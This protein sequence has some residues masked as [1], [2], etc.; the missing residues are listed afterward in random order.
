MA[1]N[2]FPFRSV[3][4][5]WSNA[6]EYFAII[7][8]KDTPLYIKGIV[9]LAVL[10]LISP[11]DLVPD[12]LAG[13]GIVDDIAVVSLLLSYAIRLVNKRKNKRTDQNNIGK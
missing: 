2:W 1:N 11:F 3:M 6:K 5:L 9:G 8:H 4:H 13:L 12:W 7:T 10:Y